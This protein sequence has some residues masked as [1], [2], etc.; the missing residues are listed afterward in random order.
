MR[1]RVAGI[2]WVTVN[3]FGSGNSDVEFALVP[4]TIDR[5]KRKDVF[6]ESYQRFG[7][8]DEFSKVGLAAIAFAMRD[9]GAEAWEQKRDIGIVAATAVGCLHTDVQYFGTVIPQDGLLASPNLFAYTLPN[10][11]LGEAAIRFGLTGPSYVV[12]QDGSTALE[13]VRQ[14]IEMLA[15]GECSAALVGVCNPSTND[16]LGS[17]IDAPAGAAFALL[18]PVNGKGVE[19]DCAEGKVSIAGTPCEDWESFVRLTRGSNGN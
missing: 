9:A 4:G 2:G 19:V 17:H 5:L 11:F 7:R 8:L 12:T 16:A 3:G 10:C 15:W 6:A 13:P 18:K 1:A 14:G